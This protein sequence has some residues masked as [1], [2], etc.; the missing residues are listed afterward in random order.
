MQKGAGRA[1]KP[2][3]L[4]PRHVRQLL[5]APKQVTQILLSQGW[6]LRLMPSS[7]YPSLQVQLGAPNAF[8]PIP[9]SPLQTMH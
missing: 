4:S 9:L 7:K 3:P 6:Q 2:W 1:P 5:K 8:I